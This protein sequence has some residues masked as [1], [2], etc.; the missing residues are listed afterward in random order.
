[1]LPGDDQLHDERLVVG[2]FRFQASGRVEDAGRHFAADREFP[3]LL[4][5][6]PFFPFIDQSAV[7][8]GTIRRAVVDHPPWSKFVE[9]CASPAKV[10]G[11]AVAQDQAVEPVDPARMQIVAQEPLVI[12]RTPGIEEPVLAAGA[13]VHGRARS[14]IE[15]RDFGA[16]AA[17]PMGTFHV[18]VPGR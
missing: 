5:N 11:I 8:A 7:H 14:G 10:E 15:H 1:M 18:S 2:R 12:A 4:G 9:Q 6:F 17:R 3:A 16:R 13:D